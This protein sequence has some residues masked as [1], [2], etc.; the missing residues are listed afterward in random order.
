MMMMMIWWCWTG[1]RGKLELR[2][3]GRKTAIIGTNWIKE[4]SKERGGEEAG[5]E[6]TSRLSAA[7]KD[8]MSPGNCQERLLGPNVS[9]SLNEFQK[10]NRRRNLQVIKY[11]LAAA[12]DITFWYRWPYPAGQAS[13]FKIIL[14]SIPWT[15]TRNCSVIFRRTRSIHEELTHLKWKWL[16]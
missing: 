12:Q 7:T 15:G 3:R 4:G 2:N 10:L 6:T 11:Y 9:I 8:E 16:N 1:W 14:L 13:N 5:R